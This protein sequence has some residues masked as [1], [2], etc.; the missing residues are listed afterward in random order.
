MMIDADFS[1]RVVLHADEIEWLA[2]PM[3]GVKRRPLDRIGGEVA[4]AT[5]IVRF[6]PGSAFSPHIHDGGEEFI[7]LEGVF[8][9]ESGDFP[10]GSYVRNP[11][12]SRHTPA[13]AP[14]CTIFVK[15]WQFDPDDRTQVHIDMT[16]GEAVPD[17]ARPGVEVLPLY[18]DRNETVRLESYAPNASTRLAVPGGAELL[19]L[20]GTAAES[21]DALRR[22]SWVRIPAGG[23]IDLAAGQHGARI[24]VKTGHLRKITTPPTYPA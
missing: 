24:W 13:S 12:T 21:G 19:V 9:D 6:D 4:R 7:V 14:G 8:Q 17:P 10:A 1:E 20:E 22:N 2:S 23:R 3:P 15:L 5:T 16:S 18:A 11:P